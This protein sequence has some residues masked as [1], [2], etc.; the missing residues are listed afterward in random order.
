MK[1]EEILNK[2]IEFLR[3]SLNQFFELYDWFKIN[4]PTILKKG[5]NAIQKKK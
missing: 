3:G 1:D 2:K 4:H 5:I